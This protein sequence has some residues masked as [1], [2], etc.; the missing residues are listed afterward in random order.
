MLNIDIKRTVSSVGW[1]FSDD[2][3]SFLPMGGKKSYMVRK[4]R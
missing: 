4:N 2:I 1:R 3:Y